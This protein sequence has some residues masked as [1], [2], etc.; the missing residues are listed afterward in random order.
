MGRI[1]QN[2]HLCI[3]ASCAPDGDSGF[4]KSRAISR[5]GIQPVWL[6][7]GLRSLNPF[8][9]GC[10][11]APL[12]SQ[13]SGLSYILLPFLA[14][15]TSE[16][17]GA[18]GRLGHRGWVLQ[19]RVMSRHVAFFSETLVSWTCQNSRAG[20]L[21]TNVDSYTRQWHQSPIALGRTDWAMNRLWHR[22]FLEYTRM[23]LT[24]AHDT[25]WA[26]SGLA[27]EMRINSRAHIRD[28]EYYAGLWKS[29]LLHDICWSPVL[30]EQQPPRYPEGYVATLWSWASLRSPVAWL[31]MGKPRRYLATICAVQVTLASP[32]NIYRTVKNRRLVVHGH[33]RPLHLANSQAR[34]SR[35]RGS[36]FP[37]ADSNKEQCD[38][39]HIDDACLDHPGLAA[40][41][42]AVHDGPEY[43]P[44]YCLPIQYIDDPDGSGNRRDVVIR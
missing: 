36:V 12:S 8:A 33:L 4:F 22:I 42:T 30:R 23:D 39:G 14:T 31:D 15:P 18:F 44:T 26:L 43:W 10:A 40:R 35:Q 19:E 13:D 37:G 6:R 2:A 1:Y 29:T 17:H 5:A 16:D 7:F 25:L 24:Y 3:H 27:R 32:D 28:E 11:D 20:K 41:F 34:T 21:D 38:L 9:A